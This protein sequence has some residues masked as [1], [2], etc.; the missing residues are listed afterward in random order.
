MKHLQD[1]LGFGRTIANFVI[2]VCV[3]WGVVMA[4][5]EL[6]EMSTS[7]GELIRQSRFD[8]YQ[9]EWEVANRSSFDVKE[10]F[11]R[12]KGFIS[13]SRKSATTASKLSINWWRLLLTLAL[14]SPSAVDDVDVDEW[15]FNWFNIIFRFLDSNLFL[16]AHKE[17]K[18]ASAGVW[19]LK[20]SC[21]LKCL[22]ASGV[23]CIL[24]CLSNR[25][26]V[27]SSQQSGG[28]G[29][30]WRKT[31]ELCDL[32]RCVRGLSFKLTDYVG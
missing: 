13:F 17:L 15:G 32:A 9:E 10:G 18:A 24:S 11:H 28:A 4:W 23:G 8:T 30:K 20:C 22:R 29:G 12:P 14:G 26:N 21:L 31:D 7:L 6:I 1:E 19:A 16:K 5:V 27:S 25:L 2:R 3:H